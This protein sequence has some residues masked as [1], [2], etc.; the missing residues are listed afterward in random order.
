[1]PSQGPNSPDN[2]TG[3]SWTNPAN[4][5]ANDDTPATFT[6]PAS[7][8]S[9]RH[10]SA[11]FDF[12]IPGTATPVGIKARLRH[13]GEVADVI[14]DAEVYLSK[15][16]SASVGDNHA[17]GNTIGDTYA[18]REYGGPTDLWG[19]TWSPS[20]LNAVTLSVIVRYTNNDSVD[21]VVS[22]D[23]VDLEVT[24]EDIVN[25]SGTSIGCARCSGAG[26]PAIMGTGT[27]KGAAVNNAPLTTLPA[28]VKGTAIGAARDTGTANAIGPI[29]G[30]SV[31]AARPS[32]SW[33]AC[34]T[35]SRAPPSELLATRPS[36]SGPAFCT[37]RQSAAGGR[38]TLA[39]PAGGR[40]RGS[41]WGLR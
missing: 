1:M 35:S 15:N 32:A 20:E 7:G 8:N 25:G 5:T 10:F 6:V 2:G 23:H 40:R 9:E 27:S 17:E 28:A 38:S 34:S 24:Y 14:Q 39:L 26:I 41:A 33:S 16:G 18:Y 19:T 21:R 11:D 4:V 3:T 36:S 22:L 29:T 12:A 31:G 13:K 37:A 30:K